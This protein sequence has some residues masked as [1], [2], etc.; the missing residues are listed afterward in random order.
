MSRSITSRFSWPSESGLATPGRLCTIVYTLRRGGP[1]AWASP[2]IARFLSRGAAELRRAFVGP[3]LRS[4]PGPR[5]RD[6]V[7]GPDPGDR[8]GFVAL[9]GVAA[10]PHRTD[11]R[12]VAVADEHTAG[13]GDHAPLE[14]GRQRGDEHRHGL[15][16]AGV[17]A[18]AE[19]HAQ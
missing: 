15:G 4:S 5:I 16:P 19:A 13:H 10:D 7:R 3:D 8:A 1:T 9:R 12:A 6:Q 14:C 11:E 17:L 18:G 2:P